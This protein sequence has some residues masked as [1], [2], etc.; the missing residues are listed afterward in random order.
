M[1]QTVQADSLITL[2][3]RIE[4]DN[5]TPVIDT[6]QG[7]PATLQL[8]AGEMIPTLEDCVTGLDV[9]RRER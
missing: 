7:T 5:G 2:N 8:G 4:L 1:S 3:Y 6:F 9:G